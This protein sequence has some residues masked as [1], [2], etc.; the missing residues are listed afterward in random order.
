MNGEFLEALQQ[1]AKEKD[2]PLETLIETV[3]SALATAYKR[4]NEVNGE[5]KVRIDSNR[6]AANPFR[7]FIEK[8]IVEEVEDDY[9]QMSLPDA[10]KLNPDALLGEVITIAVP[11][12]NFGRIAAQTA[13]QVVV[14]R[15]REAERRKIFDDY[16]ERVGEVVTGT[17]QRREG[18]NVV[19]GAGKTRRDAHTAGAGRIGAVPLQRPHQSL[20]TGSKGHEQ[21]AAGHRVADA[22]EPDTPSF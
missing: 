18:R 15:I 8:E 6:A 10:R 12:E 7:V 21:R 5:I 22:S 3:E 19:I 1:I 4:N 13:K 2:I 17:V 16:N 9:L 20:R 11:T 14:Q